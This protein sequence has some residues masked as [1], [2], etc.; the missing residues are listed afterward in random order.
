MQSG[1]TL[2]LC[3]FL[4]LL[5]SLLWCS[6]FWVN[7]SANSVVYFVIGAFIYCHFEISTLLVN[8]FSIFPVLGIWRLIIP[9]L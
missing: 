9:G 4:R 8:C 1:S 6:D 3:Q 2:E 5:V 7:F